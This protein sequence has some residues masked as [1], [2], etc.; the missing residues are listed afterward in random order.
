MN[1]LQVIN[2]KKNVLIND[3]QGCAFL[4]YRLT[5]SGANMTRTPGPWWV[6]PVIGASY[7]ERATSTRY[8]HVNN[9]TCIRVVVPIRH[10]A[11]DEIYIY[12]I[13]SNTPIE[14]LSIGEQFVKDTGT[15]KWVPCFVFTLYVSVTSDPGS[16]LR[17]VEVYV[18]SNKLT[19]TANYGMEVFDQKG[20]PVFNSANYYIRVKDTYFKEFKPGQVEPSAFSE[21]RSYDVSK[22][23]I[24]LIRTARAQDIGIDGTVVSMYPQAY[25]LNQKIEVDED[26]NTTQ[27]IISELDQHKHFPVSVDLAEI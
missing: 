15:N 11:E 4:K 9:N 26:Y 22:L 3:S 24:T 8:P 17:G 6:Y 12:S 2:N 27:Y 18:Y 14:T 23:G 13:T 1:T 19:N 25:F 10:R 21:S 16:I 7:F 20:N 5:F